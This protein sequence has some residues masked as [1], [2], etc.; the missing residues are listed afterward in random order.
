MG[1]AEERGINAI[2]MATGVALG[3]LLALGV[4]LMI[5]LLGS[6]AVSNGILKEDA[7]PQLT[8]AAC[9]LGCFAGGLLACVRW[10]SRR[11]LGGLA[12]GAVCY[13]LILA[14][15]LLINDALA[16]GTQALIELAGCLCGG[17]LAGMLG[18]RRKK[19]RAPGRKK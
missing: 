14:I 6:A 11:L 9:V 4:E 8:A 12:T 10:K 18:G 5:L 13:L 2:Q 15:G 17:A 19:K 16:L 3:G 1:K 7:A